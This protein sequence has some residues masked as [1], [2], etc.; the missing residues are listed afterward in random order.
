MLDIRVAPKCSNARVVGEHGMQLKISLCSAPEGGAANEELI[1]FLAKRLGISKSRVILQS[2]FK[3]RSK[4]ILLTDTQM[5]ER[6]VREALLP[7]G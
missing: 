2:G 5:T 4:R 7:D 1:R 3:S 6:K